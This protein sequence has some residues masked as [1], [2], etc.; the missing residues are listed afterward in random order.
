MGHAK[1]A[2]NTKP[3]LSNKQPILCSEMLQLIFGIFWDTVYRTWEKR[4]AWKRE[5]GKT[6]TTKWKTSNSPTKIVES[7]TTVHGT[8]Y[9]VHGTQHA[10]HEQRR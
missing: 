4:R 10:V 9:A 8:Q 5:K 2:H 6:M 1:Q 7:Y 3:E